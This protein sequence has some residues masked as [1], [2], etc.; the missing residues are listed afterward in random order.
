MTFALA[1][2]LVQGYSR[3][4]G[5]IMG[6]VNFV[7]ATKAERDAGIWIDGEYVGYVS[8]LKG[9]K[10]I[11]LLPGTH[12]IAARASGYKEFKEKIVVEPAKTLDLTIQ[13]VR[14]PRVKYSTVTSQ[15]K[16]SVEPD[17][18]AVFLDG[19]FVGNVHEFGGIGRSM[20]VNPGKHQ[21][22]IALPGYHDFTTE[23]DL[24]PE[25]KYTIKTKLEPASITRAGPSIKKVAP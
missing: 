25:Q 22:K 12:E 11:V 17:R 1:L 18:A 21:I 19:A 4:Q 3:A 15:I 13:M 7:P 23:V 9:D 24:L 10:K 6:Q 14:D 5:K 2:L 8:E 16:I 20:L